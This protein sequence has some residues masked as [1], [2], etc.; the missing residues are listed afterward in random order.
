MQVQRQ[1]WLRGLGYAMGV[2]ALALP[3]SASSAPSTGDDPPLQP[4]G[5]VSIPQVEGR[6]YVLNFSLNSQYNSNFRRTL[7]A[8]SNS[9]YRV[10]PN[11]EA[12]L[13]LPVGRQQLFVGGSIGRDIFV[14]NSQFN[15]NRLRFGGGANLRAGTRCTGSV[16]G[17]VSRFQNLLGDVAEIVDNVQQTET[18]GATFSCQGP[19]G[20]GF[21]G[22]V[23]YRNTRNDRVERELFNFS[24]MTYSPQ[25][26]YASPALGV[27]S[28]GGSFQDIK[29]PDRQV[30]TPEGPVD[31][32]L[33]IRS[34]RL[35]Y[36]RALGTRLNLT[37]G[38]STVRVT[39]KPDSV[40]LLVP[41]L[42]PVN[43][44]LPVIV[45]DRQPYNVAG[46]DGALSL[47]LGD[48]ARI[49]ASTS[50]TAL[51]NANLGTLSSVRNLHGLDIDFA[52]RP[53]LNAGFGGTLAN[54]RY[55]G[56]FASPDEPQ[57]RISD[58]IERVYAQVDYSPR[59]RVSIGVE[60]AH[61]KRI[62]NPAILSFSNTTALLRLRYSLG[63]ST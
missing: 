14:D 13:G 34:F 47:Q 43:G 27:F 61:Q 58:K 53:G 48:R 44:T 55:R 11:V 52:L 59:R 37:L 6:G 22:T 2:S 31:D 26:T 24:S 33:N 42:G 9:V 32:A 57:R 50:R 21:G 40:V 46:Y 23:Q 28:L 20:V 25:I 10:S 17:E 30:L 35:G 1:T 18:A 8:N 7:T 15:R 36:N 60:V 39:P 51:P 41:G 62:S 3:M 49:T 54:A 4:T 12:G 19:I 45:S 5:L 16:A 29:Y 56:S 38:V 63:R